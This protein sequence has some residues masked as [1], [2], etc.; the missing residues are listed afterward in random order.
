MGRER[1][2]G[3]AHGHAALPAGLAERLR[4]ATDVEGLQLASAQKAGSLDAETRAH[5]A[6]S[7]EALNEALRATM[8]R[9]TG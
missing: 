7:Y 4:V 6:E 2:E 5:Y 9:A 8:V 1:R 3:P